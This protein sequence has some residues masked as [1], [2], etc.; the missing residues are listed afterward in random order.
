[1]KTRVARIRLDG[2]VV[3]LYSDGIDYH[4][5][6]DVTVQ[7]ATDVAYDSTQKAWHATCIH[8]AFRSDAPTKPRRLRSEAIQDEERLL[9]RAL[10][11]GSVSIRKL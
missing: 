9:N 8:P 3:M 4:Q 1:M 7:R 2:T 5:I 6:G 10:K 11:D